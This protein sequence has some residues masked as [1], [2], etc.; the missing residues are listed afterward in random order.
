[1]QAIECFLYYQFYGTILML[2]NSIDSG[3][4]N[5]YCYTPTRRENRVVISYNPNTEFEI[6][7][8][9]AYLDRN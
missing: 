8:G 7:S 1:M 9:G 4:F 3:L 2:R 5:S 6:Y